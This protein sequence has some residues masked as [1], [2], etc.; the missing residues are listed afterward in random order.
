MK[1]QYKENIINDVKDKLQRSKAV[2]ITE[3]KGLTVG[4]LTN[5]RRDLRAKNGDLKI[6]KNTLFLMASRG[7]MP[8]VEEN[9]FTG[10]TAIIFSYGDP[11][12][13]AKQIIS[14]NKSNPYLVI[15]GGF[16]DNG[17]ILPDKVELLSTLPDKSM[18]I[19]MLMSMLNA[20]ITR[21]INAVSSPVTTLLAALNGIIQNKQMNK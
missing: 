5:L 13:I 15:K 6:V 17:F 7:L 12:N 21:F 2:F 10:P 20:P 18:L 8:N 11:V 3:Y 16:F 14:F 9:I 19:M 1:K 4:N